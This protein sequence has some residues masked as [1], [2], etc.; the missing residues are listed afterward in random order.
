MTRH[1]VFAFI[2]VLGL[3][4]GVC[5][6]LV[7]Y[8]IIQFEFSFDTFHPDRERIYRLVHASQ[9]S[10]GLKM[11]GVGVPG[12][13]PL[14][15]R[16][17]IPG[18]EAVAGFYRYWANIDIPGET[19]QAH[20]F[21]SRVEGTNIIGTIIA[22]SNYFAIFKYDWLAGSPST[23][24]QEPFNV[25]LSESRAHT[26]FGN[27]PPDKVVGREILYNDSLRVRVSGII[28]DWNNNTDFPVSDI[29]SFSTINSSSF[30]KKTFSPADWK[31]SS[32]SIWSFVKLSKT[33]SA[34]A[35]NSQL[36]GFP[37]R[38]VQ[39][40]LAVKMSISLQPLSDIHFND[41]LYDDFRT[42]S[43]PTLYA[44]AAIALFILV[45]AIVNFIN[46]S[47]AQS[48]QR[49]KEI[50]IRKVLGS[51]RKS[52]VFQFL[53]ETFLH[54]FPAVV[55]AVLLVRPVLSLFHD[56]IPPGVQFHL[57]DPYTLLFLFLI[58]LV[59]SLL[60]GLYPAR[61]ISSYLPVLSLK[62]DGAP[63][64]SERWWLRKGL[65]VFQFTISLIFIIGTIVIGNQLRFIRTKDLGLN[66]DAII[67]M[68]VPRRD[69]LSNAKVLG[70]KI[71]Q[72][73]GV[74]MVAAEILPPVGD[75]SFSMWL[76]YKGKNESKMLVLTRGGDEN[77]IPLYQMR[78]LAGRNLEHSDSLTELVINESF[79]KVLGFTHPQDALGKFLYTDSLR[80]D[81]VLPIVGVVAD[82]NEY[83]LRQ[84]IKPMV[85][86]HVP[87]VEDRLAIKLDTRGRQ[88]AD[89]KVILSKIEKVWKG[90]YKGA[91]FNYT[92]LDESIARMYEKE[93]RTATLTNVAMIITIF[94]S[95]MGLFGLA[96]FTAEKKTREI[97][98]RKVLGA[99]IADI[100]ALL[101]R[102]FVVLVILA[103]FI[104]SP[105][106][107]YFMH[108]WLQGF[109]YRAPIQW[110][111]FVFAGLGAIL[112]AL[113]TISFQSIKA[114]LANPVKSLR[115]E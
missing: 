28:K 84:A 65:I 1:K 27:L 87:N 89:V 58:A 64:G 31:A 57:G 36:A 81:K 66:T 3:V 10:G 88:L 74:S 19:G 100:V 103:L 114:A 54:C 79:S 11:T 59:T 42:A 63:K 34:G 76:K 61:V 40:D 78:L 33:V 22:D 43:L 13:M 112:V 17:E 92:F 94:I 86:A 107:W 90:L 75:P 95:C 45:I 82:I 55:I 15:I 41:G 37:E 20:P 29:I 73:P 96:L 67:N 35:I 101:S 99:S 69:S 109:A 71:R 97:G 46:L 9:F 7:I 104:A 44:L 70:Q 4:L 26:Y 113:I 50:G 23:S 98:I 25:V 39:S 102:D 60:A 91:P 5:T 108:K 56:F 14:A 8:L 51:S 30:L 48:I 68:I 6:C 32:R 93:R 16:Q 115:T 72:L 85:I 47:T 80:G 12:P 83:S 18:L 52:L 77:L 106:A 24:L 21:N 105:I 38:H 111:V 53:A 110:W 2:N 49:A 62:G